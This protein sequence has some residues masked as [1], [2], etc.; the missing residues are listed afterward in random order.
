MKA[1]A[2]II[3]GLSEKDDLPVLFSKCLQTRKDDLTIFPKNGYIEN[4]RKWDDMLKQSKQKA[5]G[6]MG[7]EELAYA[8]ASAL[9]EGRLA[10]THWNSQPLGNYDQDLNVGVL[11][12]D[13]MYAALLVM[14]MHGYS[15]YFGI[16]INPERMPVERAI[17]L[18][19]NAI[20]AACDRLNQIDRMD[21]S[22][23]VD[24][25]TSPQENSGVIEDVM[26][27]SLA[28][29]GSSFAPI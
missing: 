5:Q 7:H 14:K 23:V 21:W 13:Q 27:R 28:P 10:H 9:R 25:I 29:T 22:K 6:L 24:A 3:D 2:Q 16:D 4:G 8:F 26:T 12:I 20:R 17:A 1:Q 18:N 19:V 11:G 15:E